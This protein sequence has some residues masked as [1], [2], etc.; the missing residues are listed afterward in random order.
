MAKRVALKPEGIKSD[1]VI[2]IYSVSNCISK[3][4]AEYINF[5]KHNGYWLF[6]SSQLI[7]IVAKENA[8]DLAG[9]KIFY[10]EVFEL[11]FNAKETEWEPFN[12]EQSFETKVVVPKSRKL[13]GYDVVTFSVGTAP[14][15]SPLS[16]CNLASTI[17]T[18]QHC[19]TVN[20][21]VTK[22]YVEEGHFNNSEPGPFRIFSV[23]SI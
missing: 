15:C 14:E 4:F 7:E 9:T 20:F 19:L 10:Y 13:E 6:N 16:C 8:L 2:D 23:Y 21:E 5:W 17:K 3:N 11:Q 18:N 22:K 12:P 1:G